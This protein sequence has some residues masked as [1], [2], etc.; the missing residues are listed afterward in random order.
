MGKTRIIYEELRNEYKILV[1]E[2]ERKK[3]VG[4]LEMY[5]KSMEFYRNYLNVRMAPGLNSIMVG[6]SCS[7]LNTVMNLWVP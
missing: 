7:F 4:N 1:R 3:R 2:T 5:G 6:S